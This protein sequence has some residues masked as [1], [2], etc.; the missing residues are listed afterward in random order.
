MN[1]QSGVSKTGSRLSNTLY[2]YSSVTGEW[3][4]LRL[5]SVEHFMFILT[6]YFIQRFKESKEICQKNADTS[7]Y[8]S[9]CLSYINFV[10]AVFSMESDL[11]NEAVAS[12]DTSLDM[13]AK[14]RKAS[15][16][17]KSISSLFFKKN[18]NEYTDGEHQQP[19]IT[20]AE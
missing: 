17:T 12:I 7:V 19:T 8:H 16:I 14:L 2:A 18:Y 1:N 9:L 15:S 11:I 20:R 13:V 3:R 10:Y 5:A 6:T 4:L